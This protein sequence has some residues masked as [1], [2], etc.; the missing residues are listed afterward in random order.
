MMRRVS[1]RKKFKQ[2]KLHHIESNCAMKFDSNSTYTYIIN[3]K[4]VSGEQMSKCVLH[5]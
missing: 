4:H 1:E 5:F 3:E 2:K